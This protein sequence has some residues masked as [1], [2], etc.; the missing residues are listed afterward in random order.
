MN[1]ILCLL[2]GFLFGV[3]LFLLLQK[4][5]M[6]IIL[7]ILIL[8]NAANLFIFLA[9]HPL[10]TEAPLIGSD[11][12]VLQPTQADPITQALIL[13]AI[14]IGFGV[15]AFFIVLAKVYYR[16][17]KTE[18]FRFWRKISK[19]TQKPPERGASS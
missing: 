15:V 1:L 19:S 2:V 13:T 12:K 5:I 6:R 10:S 14:V 18:E 11:Q 9:S 8:G 7:A 3:G 17:E 16:Q 4:G